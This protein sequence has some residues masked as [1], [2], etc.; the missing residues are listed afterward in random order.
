MLDEG[1]QTPHNHNMLHHALQGFEIGQNPRK[2][3]NL[4]DP[5]V[6]GRKI[7]LYY[8]LKKMVGG[9]IW[10]RIGTVAG[11]CEHGTEQS[12]SIQMRGIP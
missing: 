5:S 10:L 4:E 8:M 11:C 9:F 7:M 2:R 1:L 6:N 12:G 3:G